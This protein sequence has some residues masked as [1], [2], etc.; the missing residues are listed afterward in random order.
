MLAQLQSLFILKSPTCSVYLCLQLLLSTFPR[1]DGCTLHIIR[2]DLHRLLRRPGLATLIHQNSRYLHRSYDEET[3]VDGGQ[4]V[5][6]KISIQILDSTRSQRDE[7][8]GGGIG[9][10]TTYSV[11]G[12]Q[13]T[14][15]S[16]YFP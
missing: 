3:E 8:M 16:R 15:S 10:H 14:I 7:R 5:N 4:A 6:I 9:P 1:L 11:A 13:S 12:S 2:Q